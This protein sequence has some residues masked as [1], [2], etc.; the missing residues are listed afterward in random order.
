MTRR[1][2]NINEVK[3]NNWNVNGPPYFWYDNPPSKLPK[4]VPKK[5]ITKH[6]RQCDEIILYEPYSSQRSSLVGKKRESKWKK[7]G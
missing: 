1:T 2:N 5:K 3:E 7:N 6:K 4:D